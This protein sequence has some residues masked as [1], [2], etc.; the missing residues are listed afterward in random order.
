MTDPAIPIVVVKAPWSLTRAMMVVLVI[1]VLAR[2]LFVGGMPLLLTND[3]LDY[4]SIAMRMISGEPAGFSSIRTPGYPLIVA[5]AFFTFGVNGVGVLVVQHLLGLGIALLGTFAAARFARPFWAMIIGLLLSLDGHLLGFSN[6]MLSE[7]AAS[8]FFMLAIAAAV[9]AERRVWLC[10]FGV[11][12]SVAAAAL[13][14]PVMQVTLPFLVLGLVLLPRLTV[15]RRAGVLGAVLVSFGAVA[16]PW[17]A[18]NARRGI[19][20]FGEGFGWALW[21]SLVQQD[22]YVRD[23][24]VPAEAAEATKKLTAEKD[25]GRVVWEYLA[26]PSVAKQPKSFLRDWA[27]ASIKDDKS[28]YAARVG[29][30]LLWQLNYFPAKGPIRWEQTRVMLKW[31]ATGISGES[32]RPTNFMTTIW[33]ERTLPLA[34]SG[35]GGAVRS[36]YTWW[37]EHHPGGVPQIPLFVL[38]FAGG[39]LAIRTRNG[40][41][42]GILL[43]TGAIVGVHAVMVFHQSRYSIPA[44]I[45]WYPLSAYPIASIAG[46]WRARRAKAAA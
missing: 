46:W 19:S 40:Q 10:A 32:G 28:K 38:A 27:F 25:S 18:Y 36:A 43:A 29:Y 39:V 16:G 1:G 15:A 3:S 4:A 42:A 35:R 23:Y 30:S 31:M 11:G 12:A 14:R 13:V 22:L 34:M 21:V 33:P 6:I 26:D 41:M 44:W 9:H 37:I 2:V 7:V 20:G 5:L 24:P 45:A 17:L 8:F